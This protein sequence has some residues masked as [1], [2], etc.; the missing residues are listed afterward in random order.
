MT[1]PARLPAANLFLVMLR[2]CVHWLTWC[3]FWKDKQCCIDQC[4]DK[5]DKS[6]S[7]TMDQEHEK[8]NFTIFPGP[9]TCWLPTKGNVKGHTTPYPAITKLQRN[10]FLILLH[11][12][13][14]NWTSKWRTVEPDRTLP[15]FYISIESRQVSSGGPSSSQS[16]LAID[17][18][19]VFKIP[20]PF[21]YTGWF[22]L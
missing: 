15:F 14:G 11:A 16:N 9:H 6:R 20:L 8:R 13:L 18:W 17:Q 5:H 10:D 1:K 7:W 4:I 22:S 12:K 21:H 3:E 2:K 19:P